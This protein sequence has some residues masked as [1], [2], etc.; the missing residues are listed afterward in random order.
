[1]SKPI[2]GEPTGGQNI[3]GTAELII[4][5]ARNLNRPYP[6]T[7]PIR[8]VELFRFE[9]AKFIKGRRTWRGAAEAVERGEEVG[10][11]LGVFDRLTEVESGEGFLKGLNTEETKKNDDEHV[12]EPLFHKLVDAVPIPSL[13]DMEVSIEALTRKA[14]SG[15]VTIDLSQREVD[16]LKRRAQSSIEN[17]AKW[18]DIWGK[19]KYDDDLEI[20]AT[21]ITEL[22]EA[23][24]KASDSDNQELPSEGV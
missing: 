17:D 11:L 5:D 16:F 2:E 6:T 13:T 14:E 9:V 23:F 24:K 22:E 20:K 3:L 15:T 8:T 4:G 21:H 19:S 18:E 12:A 1:M 10:G 7:L